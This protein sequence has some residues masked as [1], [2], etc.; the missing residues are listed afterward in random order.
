MLKMEKYHVD[1]Y[2]MDYQ[3]GWFGSVTSVSWP[4]RNIENME[5]GHQNQQKGQIPQMVYLF[6][7]LKA[8]NFRF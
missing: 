3:I 6:L 2:Q 8:A 1:V 5:I 7:Y 4:I